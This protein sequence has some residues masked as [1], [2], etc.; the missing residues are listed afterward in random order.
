[1][2]KIIRTCLILI[3][4]TL[5]LLAVP[6]AVVTGKD[7]WS[8]VELYLRVESELLMPT[9]S[10]RYYREIFWTHNDELIDLAFAYPNFWNES[11]NLISTFD[12]GFEALL[13]GRGSDVVITAEQ[14]A[15]AED[16]YTLLMEISSPALQRTLQEESTRYPLRSFIGLT[17]EESAARVLGPQT[18]PRP[19]PNPE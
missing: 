3:L 6:A 10:G 18:I 17:M 15:V 16:Y 1:M 9:E 2:F 4:V 14:I 19:T 12:V 8:T 11:F 7:V 13:N 5:L